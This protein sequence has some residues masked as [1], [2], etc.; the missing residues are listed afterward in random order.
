MHVLSYIQLI[1]LTFALLFLV[2]CGI[3]IIFGTNYLSWFVKL[4]KLDKLVDRINKIL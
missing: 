4:I 2:V 1:I 3:N